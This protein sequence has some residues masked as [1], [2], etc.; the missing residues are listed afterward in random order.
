MYVCIVT[1]AAL[2]GVALKLLSL[3]SFCR[4][5]APV[6]LKLL[7]ISS[8][9]LALKLLSLSSVSLYQLRAR[10]KDAAFPL[11]LSLEVNV[12]RVSKQQMR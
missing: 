3:S 2:V 7:P 12:T 11:S 1:S 9:G 10:T 6:A 8:F 5:Q 4:S